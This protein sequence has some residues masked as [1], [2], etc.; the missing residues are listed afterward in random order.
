MKKVVIHGA[1]NTSN[2]G[3]IL[4]AKMFYNE[5]QN[6]GLNT[7]FLNIP[8]YGI[9]KTC[10]SEVGYEKKLSLFQALKCDYLIMMSGGYLGEDVSSFKDTLKRYFRYVLWPN[11][12]LMCKKSVYVLGVGGGP[13]ESKW[14]RKR[15]V[16]VLQKA[17]VVTVRDYE[18]KAYFEQYGVTRNIYV[19]SDTAQIYSGIYELSLNSE[20]KNIMQELKE[21]NYKII[22]LHLVSDEKKDSLI[23]KNI[24]KALNK[25]IKTH[26]EYYLIAGN[27]SIVNKRIDE[28]E[29]YQNITTSNKVGYKYSTSHDLVSLLNECDLVIT[30]KLH[31]GI[32]SASLGKSVLAFPT[33][34]EKVERYYKQIGE[35]GRCLSLKKVN[36][37]I[38]FNMLENYHDKKIVLSNEIL[39]KAM[40]NLEYIS[41]I[42][43]KKGD[44]CEKK[45]YN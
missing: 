34:R 19:T 11:L 31:V 37:D 8:F 25:F 35:S 6:L 12:F 1:T 43:E 21:K 42:K 36:S 26:P 45:S 20:M 5:C 3:D 16:N 23:N 7:Y 15:I 9:G 13:I 28:Y 29:S 10:R 17:D 4:F 30:T 41:L 32:L 22:Y 40:K 44:N 18:T 2:F 38:V 24:V 14:L 39:K 33:H 27:D